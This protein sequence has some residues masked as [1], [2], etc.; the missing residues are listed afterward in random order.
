MLSVNLGMKT[1][2]TK[3]KLAPIVKKCDSVFAVIRALGMKASGGT[4][5]HIKK[6][7]H[8]HGLDTAHFKGQAWAADRLMSE[9]QLHADTILVYDRLDGRREQAYQ[10]RKSLVEVGVPEICS[11]CSLGK[12]WNGK[13]IVLE[14]DHVDGNPVNNVKENL[15][16]LCPNCH[17]QTPTA[18]VKNR[19][20]T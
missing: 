8:L 14:V 7:I 3:E 2:Y 20:R 10:L 13:L 5:G 15:R 18:G 12:I 6:M 19:K 9:W 16:F 4:H 17:S 1:K 11:S